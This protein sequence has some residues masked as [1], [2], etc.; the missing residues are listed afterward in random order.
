MPCI[1]YNRQQAYI[2]GNEQ[3]IYNG[4][5]VNQY[6]EI[7]F[8]NLKNALYGFFI[9]YLYGLITAN[10][11]T[12]A[13]YWK[14]Q[15][16]SVT[17]FLFDSDARGAKGFKA[18]LHGAAYWMRFKNIDDLYNVLRRDLTAESSSNQYTLNV[19][20]LKSLVLTSVPFNDNQPHTNTGNSVPISSSTTE[21]H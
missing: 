6:S 19:Y 13:V 12:V 5:L 21:I 10:L 11:T 1:T 20:S 15:L 9:E 14:R 17:Y 7:F 4:H 3:L 8:P 2:S 18:P 16:E